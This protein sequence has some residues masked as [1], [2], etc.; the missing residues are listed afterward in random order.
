MRT[1]HIVATAKRGALAEPERLDATDSALADRAFLFEKREPAS[2]CSAM[3]MQL[4]RE[5]PR[6]GWWVA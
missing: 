2:V 4:E 6:N 1:W 3:A 5:R